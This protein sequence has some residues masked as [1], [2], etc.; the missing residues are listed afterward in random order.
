KMRYDHDFRFTM[1][2]QNPFQI[3]W[4]KT[5]YATFADFILSKVQ[6]YGSHPAIIDS[7]S[8]KQWRFSEI[9]GWTEMCQS[10]L[11]ELGVT[12]ASR[13]ALITGTTGQA[14]FVHLACSMIGCPT[15]CVNGF[16]TIDE[17]WQLV[18]ISESTHLVAEPQFMQKAE[19]V[20]RKAVMR[21]GGRIKHVRSID[22]VL[23]SDH[24]NGTRTSTV[25]STDISAK[26]QRTIGPLSREL[27]NTKLISP[28]TVAVA[29]EDECIDLPSPMSDS[30]HSCRND[31]TIIENGGS[32]AP[33][34]FTTPI[35]TG[36]AQ[37]PCMIFFTSGTTGLP[38]AAEITRR[39]LIIN[40]Q[41][42][43]CPIFGPIQAKDKLLLPL[44]I[45]HLFGV[46]SAYY[47]LVNGG[48]VVTMNRFDAKSTVELVQDH[49]ISTMHVTP[50]MLQALAYE[51]SANAD[52]FASVRSV[53]VGGAPLDSNIASLCKKKMALRD[54]R[55]TYGMTEL[56]GLCTLSHIECGKVES[57][58]VPLPG[59][60]FKIVHWETKQLMQPNQIGQ[61][62]VMGPQTMPCYYKNPK[63]TS[64]IMDHQGFVKTGD[65]A[66]YDENGYV[67]VLDR[68]K[69]IIK[70]KGTLICPSEVELILRAHPGIDDCAVVGRQDHVSGEVPAAFVVKSASHPL[71]SSAEVRQY[72]S[73]KI[74]TFK[75]LRGGVFFI[76]EI[77]RS[78]CGKVL[79]RHL[80]QFWDRERTNSKIPSDEGKTAG[81][82]AGGAAKSDGKRPSLT[83]GTGPKPPAGR[84]RAKASLSPKPGPTRGKK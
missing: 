52:T 27:S 63:A 75:E 53:I 77:P 80:R 72:V 1:E 70:H 11:R 5:P 76:S 17:I 35:P 40:L 12:A 64:E 31:V 50:P 71:L 21:G 6:S 68:I 55:Q 14:V 45:A 46:I 22:D 34:D 60:L 2:V 65:A 8:G 84:G 66:F 4:D 57:V 74:A 83:T 51:S 67:Y 29:V 10:R 15:V 69:D 61:L 41:Q 44:S 47:A 16:G 43:S 78:S 24:I 25:T 7:D 23:T 59:M 36:P 81:K 82:A 18:D 42:M 49:K 9:K 38:K 56:G 20:K 3:A 73:G 54:L 79:R 32:E 33:S 13:V 48:T 28:A 37:Q 62:L 26:A 19:D 58:G 30:A 39:S